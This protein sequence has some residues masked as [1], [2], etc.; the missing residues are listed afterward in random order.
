M[1]LHN[2]D[3]I[4]FTAVSIALALPLS[5]IKTVD[6]Q[7]SQLKHKTNQYIQHQGVHYQT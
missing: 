5:I 7:E 2:N 4:Y 1:V 3:A 6:E